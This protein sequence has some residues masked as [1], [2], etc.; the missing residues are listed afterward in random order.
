MGETRAGSVI[1][2][3]CRDMYCR[4]NAVAIDISTTALHAAKEYSVFILVVSPVCTCM[5]LAKSP[6]ILSAEVTFQEADFFALLEDLFDLV[7]D[8]ASVPSK[9]RL[10]CQFS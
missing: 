3:G 4:L 10:S 8:Y 6:D 1:D 9:Q 2:V 7:Y 5:L